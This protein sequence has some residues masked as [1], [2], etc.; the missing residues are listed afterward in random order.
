MHEIQWIWK[1]ASK[2][3]RAKKPKILLDCKIWHISF[4]STSEYKSSLY[5]LHTNIWR[6]FLLYSPLVINLFCFACFSFG[7]S[8][9]KKI[10]TFF[11]FHYLDEMSKETATKMQILIS[12]N[13]YSLWCGFF[14][15]FF[16][17]INF[18][19][20]F[21]SPFHSFRLYPFWASYF[22]LPYCGHKI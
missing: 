19:S 5:A 6:E 17:F 20:F 4:V 8:E 18:P 10:S 9:R 12:H 16:F 22:K 13:K 7:V 11:A 14:R 1:Q 2:Q 15:F 3:A 21:L